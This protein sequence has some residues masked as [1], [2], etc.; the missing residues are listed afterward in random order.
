VK[1]NPWT[2][3]DPDG[4]ERREIN[5]VSRKNDTGWDKK[6]KLDGRSKSDPAYQREVEIHE[7]AK[8]NHAF[9]ETNITMITCW[10]NYDKAME[11]MAETPEGM[12]V[13]AALDSKDVVYEIKM[14]TEHRQ[15]KL[16]GARGRCEASRG[17]D[18]E[19]GRP[20]QIMLLDIGTM[21]NRTLKN[22]GTYNM[23][24]QVFET[25]WHESYHGYERSAFNVDPG[26]IGTHIKS[27][28]TIFPR[29]LNHERRATRFE[30]II[31]ARSGG[32]YIRDTYNGGPERMAKVAE[33]FGNGEYAEER[34]TKP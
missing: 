32:A 10:E 28:E 6:P 8:K 2:S 9:N 15:N 24:S 30:N 23:D 20:L 22:D 5:R 18:F 1:Q 17:E 33:P 21:G 11:K 29:N 34:R 27:D 13:L 19:D 12:T 3:F 4:L 7:T 25:V 26:K 31:R 14:G 16:N